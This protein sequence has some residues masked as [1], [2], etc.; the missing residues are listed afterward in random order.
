[1]ERWG[2]VETIVNSGK[3]ESF[4][5]ETVEEIERSLETGGLGGMKGFGRIV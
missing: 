1:V 5:I 4:E 2:K 3:T